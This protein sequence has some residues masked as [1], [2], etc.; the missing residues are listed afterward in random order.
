MFSAGLLRLTKGQTLIFLS[1]LTLRKNSQNS[2][3]GKYGV[4]RTPTITFPYLFHRQPPQE[5]SGLKM[6]HYCRLENGNG[7][8]LD[9]AI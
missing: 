2:P 7:L 8:F 1:S 5:K 3:L 4:W 9:V 6:S